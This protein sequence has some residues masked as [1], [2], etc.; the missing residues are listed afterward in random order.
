MTIREDPATELDTT[1]FSG[2][3]MEPGDDGY[4]EARTGWN[5]VFDRH[6]ALILRCHTVADVEA[7]V[8][9]AGRSGLEVAVRGGGHSLSG[10]STTEGGV[11]IDLSGMRGI[12]VDPD[13]R[14]ASV[15]PGVTWGELD[16]ATAEH[17]F[18]TTG[19]LIPST[20]VAGLT[21]GGG[22]GWLMRRH[23]LACDNL[24]AADVVTAD[25]RRVRAGG[26]GDAELLWGLRGG[27]GNFGVV[28]SFELR[29]HPVSTVLG[30]MAMFPLDRGAEVLRAYRSWTDRLPDDFTTIAAIV[31]APPA[32]FVP[33]PLVGKPVVA[34]VGCFVGDAE[35]GQALLAP[36]RALEPFADLFGPMP[37]PAVQ[38]MLA[39]GAPAGLRSYTSSGYLADLSDGLI[40]TLVERGARLATPMSQLH[41]HHMGG[42]V[43]RVGENDTAFGHRSA[44][45]TYNIIGTWPDAGGDAPGTAWVRETATA[46]RPFA[47]GGVYV[48]FLGAGEDDRVRAAYDEATFERLA[49][50]KRR[51]DPANLFRRNHNIPPA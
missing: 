24:V 21:L 45:F 15:K 18:A 47:S 20:G 34:V 41:L 16:A 17:G 30:G 7:A 14:I 37:Y 3:L 36:I 32:P 38:G 48:N 13:A 28:T 8:G 1:A 35:S 9:I 29:L 42:A 43:A 10:Q 50:L 26:D 44:A 12:Q 51:Y 4:D 23:G 2:T 25:G 19:G 40:H 31:G 49:A 11:L 33:R 5:A 46:V 27:G 39:A 22:I 6:P